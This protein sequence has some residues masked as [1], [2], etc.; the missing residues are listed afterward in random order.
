MSAFVVTVAFVLSHVDVVLSMNAQPTSKP[1]L[2]QQLAWSVAKENVGSKDVRRS[3][4]AKG[5]RPE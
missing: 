1:I 3:L 4:T 2:A 5:A